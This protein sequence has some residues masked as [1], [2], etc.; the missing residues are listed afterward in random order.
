MARG[1]RERRVEAMLDRVHLSAAERTRLPKELSGGQQQRVALARALVFEP[2]V[3]LLD[4][5]FANLD[6]Q[7]RERLRIELKELQRQTGVT[8]VLVTHDQDE[9][10]SL[11]DD[12]ALMLN[13]RLVQ[14]GAPQVLYR[15]PHTVLAARLLGD[16]NLLT[17]EGI[18]AEGLRCNG[19]L[20]LPHLCTREVAVGSR[21]LVR[22]E[23][24]SLN[25]APGPQ[26]WPGRVLTTEYFG[27]DCVL[28]IEVAPSV[29]LRVRVRP[30]HCSCAPG[31]RVHVSIASE[32]LW[33]IPQADPGW[34]SE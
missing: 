4:E 8:T 31:D 30:G 11:A 20:R 21:V 15:Q 22:P 18:D 28:A 5:P 23:D 1:E 10:L 32:Q 19:G 3:L 33:V 25:Q 26:A 17:V 14:Y 7:L 2:R 29:Q 13:G 24:C 6:R 16:S 34:S 12:V 27:V 9:A